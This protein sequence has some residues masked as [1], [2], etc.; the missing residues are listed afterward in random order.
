MTKT[1]ILYIGNVRKTYK[2][3]ESALQTYTIKIVR[4]I[5]ITWVPLNIF[6]LIYK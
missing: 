5:S 1:Y 2:E 6:E 4:I 3:L